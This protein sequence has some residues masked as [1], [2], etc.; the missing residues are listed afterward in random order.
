MALLRALRGKLNECTQRLRGNSFHACSSSGLLLLLSVLV[1]LFCSTAFSSLVVFFLPLVAS[2]SICCA[3]VYLLVAAS[4]SE[5]GAAAKEVVLV[6]GDRAEVGMLQVFDGANATVY[7][8][9]AGGRRDVDV[10]RVG[11]FLHYRSG[12]AAGGGGWT[13]RGVDQDGEEVVFAGR[14]AATGGGQDGDD[15]RE[16]EE[17]LAALRVDRL[18]EGVW[19]SYFGGWSRWNYVTD[20][21]DEDIFTLASS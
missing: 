9:G 2:T 5:G 18:A 15:G 4:E 10:T 11:C 8:A 7:A 19:D 14:L 13:K 17:E 21:Y 16:L 1:A 6:S 3:A 12:G 20:E